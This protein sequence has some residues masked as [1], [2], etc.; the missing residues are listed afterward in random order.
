MG[1][2][3]A[4]WS[5]GTDPSRLFWLVARVACDGWASFEYSLGTRPGELGRDSRPDSGSWRVVVARKASSLGKLDYVMEQLARDL[6]EAGC[7]V[8]PGRSTYEALLSVFG[9]VRP[10]SKVFLHPRRRDSFL[11]PLGESPPLVEHFRTGFYSAV[12]KSPTTTPPGGGE[13]GNEAPAVLSARGVVTTLNKLASLS[14]VTR[15]RDATFFFGVRP[16]FSTRDLWH[17]SLVARIA[18]PDDPDWDHKLGCFFAHP[19][20]GE[21]L[22][23]VKITKRVLGQ[24][25]LRTWENVTGSSEVCDAKEFIRALSNWWCRASSPLVD[26]GVAAAG[27]S[28]EREEPG[29]LP[30]SRSPPPPPAQ[31]PD[32]S[33][34]LRF[35]AVTRLAGYQPQR[36][37]HTI[38][39]LPSTHCVAVLAE[40]FNPRKVELAARQ[41]RGT[42]SLLVLTETP[43]LVPLFRKWL[44]KVRD[45][46]LAR[47]LQVRPFQEWA[48]EVTSEVLG[49]RAAG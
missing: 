1:L 41:R 3:V 39:R 48:D 9:P 30:P 22:M 29:P 43:E 12:A 5:P 4:D 36:V 13:A 34:E 44:A 33:L 28:L 11:V 17:V 40:T 37:L 49:S 26:S 6:S 2:L 18:G 27:G 25:L 23:P 35:F 38:Y 45:L 19:F 46:R 10:G 8:V 14:R 16:S 42:E 32:D 20:V 21:R 31:P 15:V 47:R 24:A 7:E